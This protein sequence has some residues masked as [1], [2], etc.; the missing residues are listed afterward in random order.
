MVDTLVDFVLEDLKLIV[1]KNTCFNIADMDQIKS[2]NDDFT[3]IRYYLEQ[4]KDDRNGDEQRDFFLAQVK[5]LACEALK[6]LD[7]FIVNVILKEDEEICGK[8]YHAFD[9]PEKLRYFAEAI[10]SFKKTMEKNTLTVSMQKLE[11][12]TESLSKTIRPQVEDDEVFMGFED[13]VAKIK[14]QLTGDREQLQVISI[15][16]MAGIGKTTLSRH[17]YND[18]LIRYHFYIRAWICVSREY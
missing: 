12:S 15:V 6:Y 14:D 5:D 7:S 16:G 2:V 3:F 13:D 18:D 1:S 10:N 8:I 9:S 11:V 4:L 17:L